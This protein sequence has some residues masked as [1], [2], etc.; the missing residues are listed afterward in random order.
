MKSNYVDPAAITQIIGCVFNDA[1]ILDETDKYIIHEEDFVE[2]FHKIVFGSIYNIHLTGSQ[3][4][5]DAIIDYLANRPKYDAIFKQNK[6]IEY[7]AEASQIARS[8]TFNYYYNRLKKFS[9]LRAYD[10][11]GLDVSYLYDPTNILDTKKRQ[12]QEDW[13]DHVSLVEIAH[14]IDIKMDEIKSQ[15]IEDDL[16]LGYQA[17]DGIDEL[18]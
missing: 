3:V 5:I 18:I 10:N 1:S 16:G 11:F 8:E 15:Y 13:L 17:G 7:L 4:N 14:S 2:D 12:Q 6:G 9:L